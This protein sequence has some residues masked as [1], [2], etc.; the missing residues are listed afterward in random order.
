M[1]IILTMTYRRELIRS[2]KLLAKNPKTIFL[3]QSISYP[4]N[5][6]YHTLVGISEKKKIELPVFE[7]V[8]MGMAIGLAMEGYLP[9]TCY[10]RFDFLILAMNQLINHL[11]KIRMMSRNEMKLKVIIRTSVAAKTPL[12][13]GPQHTQDYT[14]A[15]K[16]MCKEIKIIKLKK[17]KDIFPVYKKIVSDRNNFSYLLIEDG[18]K[19]NR[20]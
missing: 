18:D 15:I 1:G 12:D 6:M 8:Q 3:G 2:M 13:G 16:L 17:A 10:P 7:E 19:F 9:V 14:N 4:G 11:D 20:K 5:S